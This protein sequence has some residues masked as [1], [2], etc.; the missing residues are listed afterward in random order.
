MSTLEKHPQIT[1]YWIEYFA[2]RIRTVTHDD[3]L[4]WTEQMQWLDEVTED[5]TN[6]AKTD[7]AVADVNVDRA[8]RLARAMQSFIFHDGPDP[9]NDPALVTE[10]QPVIDAPL[11]E[12][13]NLSPQPLIRRR[14]R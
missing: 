2:E 1:G 11:S 5:L 7:C 12:P 13:G 4:S 3:T 9:D 10:T 14:G 6:L 8:R